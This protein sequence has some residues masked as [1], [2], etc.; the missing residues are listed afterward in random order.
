M[1]SGRYGVSPADPACGQRCWERGTHRARA[2][3]G[4]RLGTHPA[5]LGQT[6]P[7]RGSQHC[8]GTAPSLTPRVSP[9]LQGQAEM[10]C[11]QLGCAELLAR[12][13][14][15]QAQD[16][17]AR[18]TDPTAPALQSPQRKGWRRD[19]QGEDDGQGKGRTP[20]CSPST[21][22]CVVPTAQ[23]HCYA[24]APLPHPH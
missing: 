17:A 2:A 10:G 8:P 3:Q 13:L 18:P 14:L 21:V 6:P 9:G 22:P 4:G 15:N 11:P 19:R 20:L 1:H 5:P 12:K 23:P 24:W 7:Q 16:L